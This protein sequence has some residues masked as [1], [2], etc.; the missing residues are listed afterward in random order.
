MKHLIS[1]YFPIWLVAV[2]FSTAFCQVYL[3]QA[4]QFAEAGQTVQVRAFADN[5]STNV[6][7]AWISDTQNSSTEMVFKDGAWTAVIPAEAVQ[8]TE[9]S[10]TV[11]A[12][13]AQGTAASPDCTL[14]ICP[15]YTRLKP[16]TMA[17]RQ[18][19]LAQATWNSNDSAFGLL[20]PE[21][22]PP[23]GPASIAYSKGSIYLLDSVNGR[24]LSFTR[25]GKPRPAMKIPTT[26]ASDLVVDPTDNS[27]VVVSQLND[28]IY[29]FRNGKLNRTQSVPLKKSFAYPAKFSYDRHT[30]TLYTGQQNRRDKK[31]AV[32]DRNTAGQTTAQ[33]APQD[34]NLQVVT[35]VQGNQLRLKLDNNPQIFS[36]EFQHPTG[37]VDEALVD[38]SG[39]V[40]ILY[41]LQG[42]YRIRRLARID[43][44]NAT[45]ETALINVWF[46]FDAT[47]RMTL[48]DNGVA[49]MTGD[50]T[51]GRI[52]AFD[53]A[54]GL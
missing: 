40:W 29:R 7:L 48:T 53:Y 23:V 24:V 22:G 43:T 19:I 34:L 18:T 26:D 4:P 21:N 39:I 31:I 8:G 28:T 51:Q 38:D 41:T 54:G 52:I 17:L 6:T 16:H 36:V 25:T 37:Y 47:R 13:D 33:S 1:R 30:K 32:T 3:S 35:E 46:S 2:T 44:I 50:E 11:T 12:D 27:L 5:H 14:Y 42:D 45:A 9:L 20:K 15:A 49:L 10:Y